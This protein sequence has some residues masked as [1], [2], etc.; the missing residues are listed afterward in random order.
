MWRGRLSLR[1][2]QA[3]VAYLPADSATAA[4]LHGNAMSYSEH[5]LTGIFDVLQLANWQR[6]GDKNATKPKPL[7]KGGG[8]EPEGTKFG[9]GRYSIDEMRVIL[10]RWHGKEA[11][12]GSS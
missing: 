6:Q 12:N 2:V 5:I 10:D 1:R 7:S 3:L 11:V 8:G 4:A 9:T